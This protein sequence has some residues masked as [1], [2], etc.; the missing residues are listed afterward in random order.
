MNIDE[1]RMRIFASLSREAGKPPSLFR[2]VVAFV[3]TV[4]LVGVALMFSVLLFVVVAAVGL[5]GWGYLWWKMRELRKQQRRDT[6]PGS[7]VIEG[8][9]IREVH[10]RDERD[11][12]RR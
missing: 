9:V 6:P 3:V 1:E 4:A 12:R 8:E 5:V 11:E 2:K 7:V 10:E